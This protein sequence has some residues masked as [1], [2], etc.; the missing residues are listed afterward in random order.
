MKVRNGLATVSSVVDDDSV[1]GGCD[2]LVACDF[3]GGEQQVPEK[4]LVAAPGK[5]DS[6]DDP[7]RHH[8][9]VQGGLG[10]NVAEGEALI[11]L[12]N[13]LRR[14]LPVTDFLKKC[15]VGHGWNDERAFFAGKRGAIDWDALCVVRAT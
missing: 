8:Q 14:D 6:R 10:G 2:P 11:V 12:V 15:L 5:P 4:R 7:F 3:C 1:A 13:D 9:N